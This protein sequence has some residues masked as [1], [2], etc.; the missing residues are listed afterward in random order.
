MAPRRSRNDPW[1][2]ATPTGASRI[3]WRAQ[4][5][6]QPGRCAHVVHAGDVIRVRR[7]REEEAAEI[8]V[9]YEDAE[10]VVAHKP[11]GVVPEELRW[12]GSA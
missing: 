3:S 2:R 7:R 5:G 11:A 12:R 1:H 9:C 10:V 6:G 8:A 4:V